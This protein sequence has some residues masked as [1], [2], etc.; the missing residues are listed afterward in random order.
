MENMKALIVGIITGIAA[1]LNPIS[2]DIVSMLAVFTLNFVFGLLAA[3]FA[4]NETFSFR[5]AWKCVTEATIF[6]VLICSVYF[7]GEQ[8][9][10]SDG[11]LQCISFISYSV[12]YFFGVNIL[13]NI[14]LLLPGSRTIGFIYDILSIEFAKKIPGLNNYLGKQKQQTE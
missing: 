6:F 7:L 3:L 4:C 10:N 1:Y 11:A 9:G 12:F 14:K 5:K 13:R 8:K 2:G